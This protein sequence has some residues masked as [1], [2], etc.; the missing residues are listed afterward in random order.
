MSKID[1]Q[2]FAPKNNLSIPNLISLFRIVLIPFI[3][4]A[5]SQNRAILAVGLVAASGATDMVDGY[6]ARR[7]NQITVLGKVLDP[8]ADKLTQIAL[9]FI[10]C[11]SFTAIIPLVVILVVKELLML[12]LGLRMMKNGASVIS[13]K[14]W[15]KVSTIAFYI[16]VV[17]IMLFAD[18][19]KNLGITLICVVISVLMIFSFCQYW[20]EFQRLSRQALAAQQ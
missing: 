6:I 12:F 4:W 11:C 9:A 3:L 7:F 1:L 13:A 15:G 20:R 8:I 10:L 2:P 17:V 18:R 19:L 14:W 5:Y 16:G